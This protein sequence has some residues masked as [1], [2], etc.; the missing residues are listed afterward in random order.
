[1]GT[2]GDRWSSKSSMTSFPPFITYSRLEGEADV[3]F[4][5]CFSVSALSI[6]SPRSLLHS[7]IDH[8]VPYSPLQWHVRPNL[9]PNDRLDNYPLKI[10]Q[11]DL[12]I[13][14]L[15]V[16]SETATSNSS[17]THRSI[18]QRL[19]LIY[20]N[21][22]RNGPGRRALGDRRRQ[23]RLGYLSQ[24]CECLTADLEDDESIVGYLILNLRLPAPYFPIC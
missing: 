4:E 12:I 6:G 16:V 23:R 8:V 1:M 19:S 17:R 21:Y 7:L 18:S 22:R 9:N 20:R 5:W 24:V 10:Q 11:L 3:S 14:S 15:T 13:D 2:D